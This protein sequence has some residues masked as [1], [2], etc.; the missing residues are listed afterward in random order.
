MRDPNQTNSTA[1]V[2]FYSFKGGVGRSMALVNVAGIMAG[3]GFRVLAL[4]MD[5]EAPGISYLMR[6]EAN[7]EGV[8]LPGFVDLLSDASTRGV[9]SD[10][11]ALSPQEVVEK[12]SYR[13]TIP[14][15]IRQSEEGLLRIMPAGQFD[16]HYQERLDTLGLGQLYRDGQGQP[17]IAAFKQIIASAAMF[18]LVFI[19]SRT[20]FS[21]ESGICTRDLGDYLVVVMGL[22]RQ[23]QAGTE[24]FLRSLRIASSK[25]KGLQVIL[26]PVPNG[27][28]DL[29][30]QR[31]KEILTALSSAW[32]E[33]LKLTLQI[34]YHPRLALTEEPHIFRRS[35]GYLYEAY[36]S[37]E[38]AVLDML[39]LT[40]ASLRK[41]IKKASDEKRLD[42]VIAQL[43]KLRKLDRGA[44]AMA[45]LVI[46]GLMDLCLSADAGELR[47]YLAATLPAD[48]WA[49]SQLAY[50]LGEEKEE[51]AALFFEPSLK[52]DPE[53]ADN[54]GNYALFMLRV[55]KNNDEAE[56]WYKRALEA[57][58]A[59]ANN[60]CNYGVFLK[61]IRKDNDG[62]EVLYKR[63][64]EADPKYVP[65]L[66]NYALFLTD[67]RK[68]YDSAEA[69]YK[70]ALDA[71]PVLADNLGNYALLLSDVRKDHDG[72]ERLYK[73]ALEVDPTNAHNLSN[74]A[75]LLFIQKRSEEGERLLIRAWEQAPKAQDLQSELLF[76]ACAH[77]WAKRPEDLAKLKSLLE[78][79]ANSEGWHLEDNVRV[80]RESGHSHPDFIAAL[81]EV[82]S[83]KAGVETLARFE[84]WNRGRF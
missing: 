24:E 57:D 16:G 82:V 21:D 10:L 42:L 63:S 80:A 41:E 75:Q 48:S 26:S 52:A 31:E 30:E 53:N 55:R 77:L 73:R 39:G 66:N 60:L 50:R 29:V 44:N 47:R 49:V 67:V 32:E 34:P 76:Y 79:G 22:N 1:F 81:A 70:R 72:A 20:G 6:H 78:S 12:Y 17:L 54:L 45:S 38:R 13:Y 15:G 18:D 9:E 51:D 68:D 84:V 4:D 74:Y 27:E 71:G 7:L 25:P 14:E 5:L 62:A 8:K 59:H 35:R 19:D 23:N 58:P 64:L 40:E 28:D 2:T 56:V 36:A 37:I 33:P 83:A 11:F 65:T 46:N 61:Q 3:R 43:K 69:L